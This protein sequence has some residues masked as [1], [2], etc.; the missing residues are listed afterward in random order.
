MLLPSSRPHDEALKSKIKSL[1]LRPE[2]EFITLFKVPFK[3]DPENV[4]NVRALAI[5]ARTILMIW[6]GAV[7]EGL[8]PAIKDLV[9]WRLENIKYLGLARD[10]PLATT[11]NGQG[12]G[13]T[14]KR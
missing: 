12:Q 7:D 14:K 10:N 9:P 13:R 8:K 2:G 3:N 6:L 5:L 11:F 4:M 1:D